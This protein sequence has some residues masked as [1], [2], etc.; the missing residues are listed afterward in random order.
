MTEI[1]GYKENF[2]C[3]RWVGVKSNS[4]PNRLPAMAV[5]AGNVRAVR[6]HSL[7]RPIAA[8]GGPGVGLVP[9]SDET[10]VRAWFQPDHRCRWSSYHVPLR[11]VATCNQA[12]AQINLIAHLEI[13]LVIEQIGANFQANRSV[14][15][16][17][18]NE[19]RQPPFPSIEFISAGVQL[20]FSV[21]DCCL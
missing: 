1:F 16:N 20:G 10:R 19:P 15:G 2:Q 18:R 3:S 13:R 17:D 9:S 6:V 12:A 14:A 21:A 11:S 4:L 5:A 7:C 8:L